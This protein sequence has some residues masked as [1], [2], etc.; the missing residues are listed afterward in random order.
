MFSQK[1]SV[2]S[3]ARSHV[4]ELV[5]RQKHEQMFLMNFLQYCPSCTLKTLLHSFG[6][7][8]ITNTTPVKVSSWSSAVS[9]EA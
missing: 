2:G 9:L 4:Q 5:P 1:M 3:G 6:L 7:E 8:R